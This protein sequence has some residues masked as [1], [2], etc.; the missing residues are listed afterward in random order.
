[1]QCSIRASVEHF[2]EAM[3]PTKRH[4]THDG[5]QGKSCVE[6]GRGAGGQVCCQRGAGTSS[7]VRRRRRPALV[8]AFL[9]A[10]STAAL[11][12]SNLSGREETFRTDSYGGVAVRVDSPSHFF[13]LK[14]A[15]SRWVLVTPE[16]NAFWMVGVFNVDPTGS[17]DDL[18]DS[19]E[20]RVRRK[21]GD[22]YG[23]G[24]HS[25][26]RLK[27]WGFNTLAEYTSWYVLPTKSP[28]GDWSNPEKIAFVA[29]IRPSYLGLTNRAGYAPG[30]FKDL[31]VGTD[32]AI[33]TGWRGGGLP[34]VFDPNFAA[35]IHGMVEHMQKEVLDSPWLIGISTDDVD[36]LFGFGPGP[37]L[38][39]PRLHPHIA[40]LVLT[41]NF[42]QASNPLLG[43]TYSD[44]K[45]Y[46]KYALCDFLKSK[47]GAIAQ[48]NAAW[49]SRYTTFGSDGGWGK[50]KGLLDENGSSPWVGNEYGGLTT[51]TPAVRADLD[52]FLYEYARHYFS[53]TSGA[54]RRAAP[55]HLV[56]GPASL[57][58]WGG[59][60]RREILRAAGQYVDVLQAAVA[61]SAVLEKTVQY[62]GDKPIV[63]WEGMTANPDSSL[64]RYPN[65][66]A[67]GLNTQGERGQKYADR[68]NF[69]FGA[70]TSLGLRPIIGFKWWAYV[71]SWGEKANWGLVSF[72][73]NAYDGKEAAVAPGRDPWGYSTGGEERNYGDF[74]SKVR[75]VNNQLRQ[76]L[77]QGLRGLVQNSEGESGR[78]PQPETGRG[79][80]I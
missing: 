29:M 32:P 53:I 69:L 64:W 24:I 56:F 23:W 8:S 38:P 79:G 40:W 47:Y 34:D 30:A 17:V 61:N 12:G 4:W 41:G 42:E 71:D 57:N 5:E 37:E 59:L 27:T 70:Q 7:C 11:L 33:Y 14:K 35:Y 73:D 9:I 78:K 2:R 49:S 43:V 13:H 22:L 20:N 21:Y 39:A 66:E 45:V 1:M 48:L 62:A 28:Y 58:G 74:I 80:R 77:G 10:V 26:K 31:I 55:G 6:E 46:S 25:A 52:A 72:L 3:A 19:H 51:A 68:E 50:G 67:V 18:A 65:P 15:G 63:T 16:G 44:R 75:Q 76:R 54:I 60:T 36:N